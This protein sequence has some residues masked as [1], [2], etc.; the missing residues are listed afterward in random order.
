[1]VAGYALERG[2]RTEF[3]QRRMIERQRAELAAHN[4]QLNSALQA[5]LEEVRQKAEELRGSRA[6]I[7][8]A[9]DVERRR[10]ERDLHDGAQQQLV[11]LAVR[12]KLAE[13]LV[14]SDE[15]ERKLLAQL[16]VE[17]QEALDNLRDLARG[18]YPPL[19]SDQGLV[20]AIRAQAARAPVEVVLHAERV[21]RYPTNVEAAVYFSVLEALQ[22]VAKYARAT[23][24][25]ITLRDVG[26]ALYLDVSDDGVGFDPVGAARGI[27]LQSMK[28]RIEALGG[29]LEVRSAPGR[30]TRVSGRIQVKEGGTRPGTH[31]GVEEDRGRAHAVGGACGTDGM[32][33]TH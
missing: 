29:S 15:E 10:I 30:G 31:P 2:L 25:V 17:A 5:S 1:M 16:R 19:L 28:D 20:P 24:A 11:A 14:G 7:V 23:R 4:V 9:A 26:D 8:V 32:R 12:L 3:L 33:W 6:R 18:I 21:A 13:S 27:G 22:N